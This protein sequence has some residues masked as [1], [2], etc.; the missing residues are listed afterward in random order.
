MVSQ[1][2]VLRGRL[3]PD[4]VVYEMRVKIGEPGTEIR[5]RTRGR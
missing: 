2:R 1:R 4:C 5:A 3:E